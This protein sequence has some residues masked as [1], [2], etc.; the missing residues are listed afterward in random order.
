MPLKV[1]SN[2]FQYKNRQGDLAIQIDNQI[3]ASA[4]LNS[5]IVFI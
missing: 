3:K 2:S 5:D 1:T 4:V